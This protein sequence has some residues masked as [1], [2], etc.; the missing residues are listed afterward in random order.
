LYNNGIILLEQ[1]QEQ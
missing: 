1:D